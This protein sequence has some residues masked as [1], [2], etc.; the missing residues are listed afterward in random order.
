VPGHARS[1]PVRLEDGDRHAGAL[2]EQRRADP[3]DPAAED[4]HV[5]RQGPIEPRKAALVGGVEPQ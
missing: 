1:D 4:G 3:D 2:Q 5:D